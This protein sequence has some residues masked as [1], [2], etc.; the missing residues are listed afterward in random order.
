MREKLNK[1]AGD[2]ILT[3]L[4]DGAEQGIEVIS[5]GIPSLDIKLGIGGVPR[6]RFT[7]F[8]GPE[9]S[10]KTTAA[11]QVAANAQRM[12]LAI[13]YIDAENALDPVYCQKLGLDIRREDFVICQPNF[14]EEGLNA[15]LRL[16]DARLI[17][18]IIIDSIPALTPKAKFE[19]I[20]SEG[21]AAKKGGV[22]AGGIFVGT[23]ARMMNDFLAVAI[24]Q[25]KKANCAVIGL[26]Q[27]R[28]EITPMG[29]REGRPGGNGWAH[30]ASVR[31]NFRRMSTDT[32]GKADTEDITGTAGK[33]KA[34]IVKNKFAPPH[35]VALFDLVFGEGADFYKNL[36]M[37]AVREDIGIKKGGSWF[38]F[39]DENG[40]ELDKVQGE[41]KAALY[42]RSKPELALKL[43]DLLSDYTGINI[44]DPGR[45][46]R[47]PGVRPEG[48]KA[49]MLARQEA[50]H[51]DSIQALGLDED[52]EDDD[53][54]LDI[55]L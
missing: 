45:P 17:D 48:P 29:A 55:A 37:T 9:Q 53:E 46:D 26:N 13:L 24:S 23:H 7:E 14:G 50:K 18:L 44:Y 36:L 30:A 51:L 32:E 11:L 6:G 38:T 42:L 20:Q 43:V 34:Q 1:Q 12:G 33:T 8:Y 40:E 15:A 28:K 21:T 10:G 25:A 5:T 27:I 39:V 22:E 31:V 4:S 47:L 3:V 54:K 41:D 19:R 49:E 35:Q 52:E 2:R 16:I